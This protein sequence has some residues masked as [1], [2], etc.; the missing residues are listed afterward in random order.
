MKVWDLPTRLYHWLQAGLVI[1]LVITGFGGNGPHLP[2][3]VALF[4]LLIWRI[5]WGIWGSETSRFRQFIRSPRYVIRYFLGRY[6]KT[7]GHNPAGGWMVITMVFAM[8]LQCTTGLL[9][10]GLVD[11]YFEAYSNYD[12][13]CLWLEKIH[14]PLATALGSLIS[15]HLVAIIV[16]KLGRKPLVWAMVTGIQRQASKASS[17]Y[18]VSNRRALLMLVLAGSVTMAII[19]LS[20]N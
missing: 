4:T 20:W 11:G 6:D 10:S 18:F 7:L 2:L 3:G 5:L 13:L 8:L 19:A 1:G 17:V 16:Y 14:G 12:S 15:L 9:M